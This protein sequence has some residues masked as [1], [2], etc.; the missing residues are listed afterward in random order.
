MK[1]RDFLVYIED[2]IEAIDKIQLEK[3]IESE[4]GK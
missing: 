3:I 2:M 1:E 4:P